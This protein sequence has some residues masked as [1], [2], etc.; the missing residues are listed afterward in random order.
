MPKKNGWYKE[1][2]LIENA[3]DSFPIDATAYSVVELLKKIERAIVLGV[4]MPDKL[5]KP[6]E[7]Q[8]FLRSLCEKFGG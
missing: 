6:D 3:P 7:L 1:N 8:S 4:E 5:L 2:L